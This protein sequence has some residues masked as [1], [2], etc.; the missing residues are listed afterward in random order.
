MFAA[1]RVVVWRGSNQSAETGR[2]V[3]EPVGSGLR[4]DNEQGN[5]Y[6][7]P[8]TPQEYAQTLIEHFSSIAAAAP[9]LNLRKIFSGARKRFQLGLTR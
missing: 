2:G 7:A 9:E 3:P 1:T 8:M 4:P 6:A 5:T